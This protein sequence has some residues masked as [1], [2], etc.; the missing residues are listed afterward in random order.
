MI[1]EGVK[2]AIEIIETK[3]PNHMGYAHLLLTKTINVLAELITKSNR[4]DL[5][6]LL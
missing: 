6:E 1:L 4:K 5:S 2:L 3:L